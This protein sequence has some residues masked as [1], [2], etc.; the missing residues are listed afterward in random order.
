MWISSVGLDR[1]SDHTS[2]QCNAYRSKDETTSQSKARD[3]LDRY[4]HY[5]TRYQVHNESLKLEEKLVEHVSRHKISLRDDLNSY[6]NKRALDRAVDVL[7]L[8]RSTLKYTY[9]FAFYLYK[10]NQADVFEQNQADLSRATEALSGFLE[11]EMVTTP[12]HLTKL[13]DKTSYCFDRRNA[14]LKHCKEGYRDH[15]WG[16]IASLLNLIILNVM[17]F[18]N[19]LTNYFL[20]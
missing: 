9:A 8:C 4:L 19:N 18:M 20:F 1:W 3:D 2:H 13:M 11:E 10:N 6:T 12:N 15:Y 16:W 17:K 5:F 7:R 14:L